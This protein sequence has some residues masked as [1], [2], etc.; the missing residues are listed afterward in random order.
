M[1]VQESDQNKKL[2][3]PG[4]DALL[5]A[6]GANK[7]GVPIF[8]FFDKTGVKLADSLAL[9]NRVNIGYPAT[10]EEIRAFQ[11]ILDKTA[12]RMT[13]AE[14]A[15]VVDYLKKHAPAPEGPADAH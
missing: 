12:P 14:R 9:P 13:V 1:T 10:P 15:S 6:N 3:T 11:T 7:S 2:E 5:A 4:A 8:M